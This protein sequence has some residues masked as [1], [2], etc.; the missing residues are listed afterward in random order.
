MWHTVI[1]Q[2]ASYKNKTIFDYF[3][4]IRYTPLTFKCIPRLIKL[5]QNLFI[6]LKRKILLDDS[7]SVQPI[8]LPIDDRLLTTTTGYMT[9]WGRYTRMCAVVLFSIKLYF[10]TNLIRYEKIL[11][12]DLF[13]HLHI[14]TNFQSVIRV[15]FRR[16]PAAICYRP[17]RH[18]SIPLHAST[19]TFEVIVYNVYKSM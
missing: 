8:C 13:F 14:A 4:Q 19:I 9:G 16:T 2:S 6:Q 11:R 5:L 12:S 10:V 3:S 7:G 18:L 17:K 15:Q 1:S